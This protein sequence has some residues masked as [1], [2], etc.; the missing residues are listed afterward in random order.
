MQR[1]KEGKNK[2]SVLDDNL[3]QSLSISVRPE[4]TLASS[5][6]DSGSGAQTQDFGSKRIKR[7]YAPCRITRH[8]KSWGYTSG[9]WCA[10][11][12][13]FANNPAAVDPSNRLCYGLEYWAWFR[14]EPPTPAFPILSGMFDGSSEST[15][16]ICMQLLLGANYM[17]ANPVLSEP[18][19]LN[20]YSVRDVQI[21]S[22]AAQAYFRGLETGSKAFFTTKA[23]VLGGL[24]SMNKESRRHVRPLG[25]VNR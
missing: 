15:H 14:T 8:P 6:A 12:G 17:R 10:D 3:H 23:A 5:L 25:K 9:C 2:E 16:Q 18:V 24:E 22:N 11:G 4:T 19:P 21:L 13:I 1:V 20:G 7:T